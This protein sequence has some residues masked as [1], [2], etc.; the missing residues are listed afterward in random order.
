MKII[1]LKEIK[2]KNKIKLNFKFKSNK[3]I[4]FLILM[5]FNNRYFVNK[6]IQ[7]IHEFKNPAE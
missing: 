4:D 2:F 6:N 3:L 1:P 7:K 5:F